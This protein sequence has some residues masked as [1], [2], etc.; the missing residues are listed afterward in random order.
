MLGNNFPIA[1]QVGNSVLNGVSNV[2]KALGKFNETAGAAAGAAAQAPIDAV[3]KFIDE[4]SADNKDIA[5]AF[6]KGVI[7][8]IAETLQALSPGNNATDLFSALGVE[9]SP[10]MKS[11]ISA[12]I[13]GGLNAVFL[14]AA[15]MDIADMMKGGNEPSRI[16]LWQNEF[17]RPHTPPPPSSVR[18]GTRRPNGEV[19]ACPP[20]Y[21]DTKPGA[22]KPDMST[23]RGVES[24]LKHLMALLEKLQGMLAGLDRVSAANPDETESTKTA[25]GEKPTPL[26]LLPPNATFEDFIFALMMTVIKDQQAEI[27]LL[28][29]EL[30]QIK[31]DRR[32]AH[33]V[34]KAA[35]TAEAGVNALGSAASAI[36]GAGGMIAGVVTQQ[37]SAQAANVTADAEL[38]EQEINDSRMLL[39]EKL[40]S[41]IQKMQE[42]V[43]ALSNIMNVMHESSMGAIRNI[44]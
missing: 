18:P 37:V 20:G 28:G 44:K 25:L 6:K 22:P 38:S 10:Q 8:G 35:K 7:P 11:G 2:G 5:Q 42:M 1:N 3:A 26:D 40:K 43:T 24:T 41:A 9:M 36:P 19:I 33:E 21:A 31:A 30:T 23:I 29:E 14:P 13:N 4:K 32:A 27:A 39:T 17:V 34:K 12:L 16:S 15:V